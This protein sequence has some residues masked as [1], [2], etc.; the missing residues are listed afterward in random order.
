M[1]LGI[2]DGRAFVRARVMDEIVVV[3]AFDAVGATGDLCVTLPAALAVSQRYD[4]PVVIDRGPEHKQWGMARRFD[5]SYTFR[6]GL[7]VWVS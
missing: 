7:I 1:G 4:K 6:G 3:P 5:W 2:Q